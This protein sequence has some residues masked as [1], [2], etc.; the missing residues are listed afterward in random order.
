MNQILQLNTGKL[1]NMYY[2]Q[3]NLEIIIL[4]NDFPEISTGDIEITPIS[5]NSVV[6]ISLFIT[7]VLQANVLPA[8]GNERFR[9]R[10]L[11]ES[12]E[13]FNNLY[14]VV[15]FESPGTILFSGIDLSFSFIDKTPLSN[16]PL[17]E[18]ITYDIEFSVENFIQG[19]FVQI[20]LINNITFEEIENPKEI[21]IKESI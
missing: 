8:T 13:I 11:K 16:T 2:S 14:S 15:P 21:I 17:G 18:S 12:N 5:S 10:V 6:R 7:L 19:E 9:V 1:L 3:D 20:A 4:G